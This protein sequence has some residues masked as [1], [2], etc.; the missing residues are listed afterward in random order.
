MKYSSAEVKSGIFIF[1]SLVL[2]FALTFVVGRY[3][4]GETNEWKIR[5][6]YISGLDENAPV[7]FA[8]RKAGKVE[9]IE[10]LPGELRP[11]R[12]TIRLAKE[13]LLRED[14]KAN[15]DML[16]LMGEKFIELTPGSE[17]A[18]FLNAD[19]EIQGDDP[20]PL[21]VMMHKMNTLTDRFDEMMIMMNPML[22]KMSTFMNGHE[23]EI[24][25]TITYVHEITSNLR[26]L[27]HDLKYRPWRLVRK[28]S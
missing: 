4:T 19:S 13:I 17:A 9:R 24:A 15:I 21:Y 16:G 22:A 3:V 5:F 1:I 28:N 11:I 7:F 25:R 27:T 23:E 20:I 26:D 2:L 18:P 12:V 14:S 10:I 8:G 6:G